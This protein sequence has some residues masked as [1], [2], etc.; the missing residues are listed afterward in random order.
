MRSILA[1][2]ALALTGTL[3]LV[4]A[5][6]CKPTSSTTTATTTSITTTTTT[7]TAGPPDATNVA[8][9]NKFEDAGNGNSN[10]VPG[11]DASG[12][13]YMVVG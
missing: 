12:P 3:D 11:F 8:L 7:T 13:V 2:A 9:N 10:N 4:A 6:V 1:F 5:S